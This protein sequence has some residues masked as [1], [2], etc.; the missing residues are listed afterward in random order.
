MNHLQVEIK[1]KMLNINLITH[2][3]LR[4]IRKLTDQ[5]QKKD[6]RLSM[7]DLKNRFDGK[8]RIYGPFKQNN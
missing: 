8:L 2:F 6:S 5:G 1:C 3:Y 7:S 4:F